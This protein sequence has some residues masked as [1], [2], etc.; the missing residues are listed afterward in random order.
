MT[1]K[2]VLTT[3][4][5]RA[6]DAQALLDAIRSAGITHVITVPDTHQRT[7]LA[8]LAETD[9]PKL[10]TVCAEDEA[11]GVNAGLYIGGAR[12]ML[13][14]QN[15]G[16]YACLNTLKAIPL[17]AEVP[18][19]MLIG[20]HGRDVTRPS[21]ENADRAARMLEPTLEAWS[22]PYY[23]LEGPEDLDSFERAYRQCQEQ[24]GPV[25]LLVG[26]PTSKPSGPAT[27]QEES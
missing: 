22:V 25:A 19:F 5:A 3:R 18:T 24:G 23:R 7:L 11:I 21:R 2:E 6:V 17:D 27:K 4:P 10:I 26:A 8:L 9:R 15:N 12:P 13:L 20:E 14:I 16:L 1:T